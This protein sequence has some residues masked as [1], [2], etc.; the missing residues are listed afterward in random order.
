MKRR[1][2]DEAAAEWDA[3]KPL[4][5]G[6]A[7]YEHLRPEHRP[8]WAA[9]ILEIFAP[10]APGAPEISALL[11]IAEDPVRWPE[12]QSIFDALRA[13]RR[14]IA[15]EGSKAAI[16]MVLELAEN[17][18]KVTFNST[19]LPAP[20]DHNSGWRIGANLQAL[21]SLDP[22]PTLRARVWAAFSCERFG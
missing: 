6:R 18:A 13:R 22:D 3:G 5:A 12:A 17:V 16:A 10:L 14:A 2:I 11:A 8:P 9:E 4:L 1:Y 20:Y 7:I 21:L 19:G 15:G